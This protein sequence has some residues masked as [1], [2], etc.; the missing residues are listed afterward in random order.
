MRNNESLPLTEIKGNC[1]LAAA[2]KGG[3]ILLA[4]QA[5]SR[6]ST[7]WGREGG[8]EWVVTRMAQ[9]LTLLRFN[10]FS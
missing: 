6:A 10:R 9:T 3:P 5:Q 4:A 1:G 7:A 2:G 8:V